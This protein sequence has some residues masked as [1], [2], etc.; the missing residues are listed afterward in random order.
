MWPEWP[1]SC[2]PCSCLDHLLAD[3]SCGGHLGSPKERPS[4][5]ELS[6]LLPAATKCVHY[7]FDSRLGVFDVPASY[8]RVEGCTSE[9]HPSF[10]NQ[11]YL[12]HT[13]QIV[14]NL[15]RPGVADL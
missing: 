5:E 11:S 8:R 15:E 4:F 12:S 1:I 6:G 9:N 10:R 2:Q 3:M 13:N 7:A 14:V